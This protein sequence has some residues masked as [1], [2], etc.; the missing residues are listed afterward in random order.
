MQYR[1]FGCTNS[2]IPAVTFGG[3]WVGGVLIHKDRSTAFAALDRATAAGID[4]IDTAAMYGDG[5]SETVIGEWLR[6]RAGQ[7]RPRISTKFRPDP[8]AGDLAGQIRR[9]VEASLSRLGIDRV[10]VLILHNQ[11]SAGGGNGTF[12]PA[13]VLAKGGVADIM[14][15]LRSDGLCAHLGLSALGEP[16]AV[17]ETVSSGRFDVAQVYYNAINP[18]AAWTPSAAWN[19]TSFDGL[20]AACQA[21][22]M[23]VMGIRIFAAG[24]LASTERHGR[25]VPIT[26]NSNDAAEAARAEAVW[27]V[28][29]DRFGTAAQASLRF[30]LACPQLSTIVVGMAEL[31]HLVQALTAEAAGPLPTAALADLDQAW[32]SHPAFII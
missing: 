21:N 25:E 22:D 17:L 31:D 26:S 24:H 32:R 16:A 11:L 12:C 13:D 20:L 28:L 7:P 29:G 6:A 2:Q 5:V 1:R 3:G 15:V 4:W 18:T 14:E 27:R 19:T 8:A 9:S 10:E 23:G 30:G